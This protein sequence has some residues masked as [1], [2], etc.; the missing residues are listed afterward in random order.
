MVEEERGA[1]VAEGMEGHRERLRLLVLAV[2]DEAGGGGGGPEDILGDLARD[3]RR[4]D[5]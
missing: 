3:Q 1:G 5:A 4:A 2:D